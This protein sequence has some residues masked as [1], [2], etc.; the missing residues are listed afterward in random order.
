MPTVTADGVL[1]VD[2]PQGL[3]SHDVVAAARRALGEKRIGHTGTLDPLATGVLPL[4]VGR[5]TRLVRFLT[6]SDKDYDATIRFG[7]TTDSFDATG[8]ETSR[9]DRVPTRDA[10]LTA[11]DAL[12]GDYLQLPP[13]FSAK[14]TDGRRAYSLARLGQTVTLTPVPVRVSRAT[15][16]DLTADTARVTLTCSAGFYVRSFAHALGELTGTGACLD[17]LRRT[18][19]GEFDLSVASSMD[20]LGPP[21]GLGDSLVALERLLPSFPSAALTDRGRL[22]VTHGRELGPE[23]FVMG[24]DARHEGPAAGALPAAWVRLLDGTGALVAMATP[25]QTPGSLHPSVVLV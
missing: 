5:A 16:L 15:L 13:A 23:D 7:L 6:A 3:T 24:H 11:I 8:V 17:A 25:G 21:S 22:H 18:R 14:K 2:K 19:S 20:R 9:T 10:L 12:T 1:V 4:A